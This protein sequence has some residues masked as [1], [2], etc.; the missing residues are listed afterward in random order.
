MLLDWI[1]IANNSGARIRNILEILG[2]SL[3]TYKR[4]KNGSLEDNRKGPLSEPKN[5]ITQEERDSVLAICNSEEF[6]NNPPSQ[7]VPELLSRSIYI[8][9]E[10]TFYRILHE[11][12]MLTHRLNSKLSMIKNK[13]TPLIATGK[14]QVWTWDITYL[15]STVRGRFFYLYLVLDIYSRKI[16]GAVV[17]E[18]ESSE[19]A[20]ILAKELSNREGIKV[21]ELT[22]HSD[23]GSPMKGA[24]MLA[25]LHE[26]GIQPSF[27]RPSVSNDNPY[28]ES[29][30]RTLKYRPEYPD[31]PFE[32]SED[33]QRWVDTFVYWYNNEHRHS[34]LNFVTPAVRHNGD[35]V[36]ELKGRAKVLE[37]AK[38]K[39][40][41]RWASKIRN[42]S[43][44]GPVY[45]NP[46]KEKEKKT[47]FAIAA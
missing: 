43:P 22:L 39:H 19:L 13:P 21:G 18:K 27:S 38:K 36:V 3:K 15:A 17:H 2:L 42:C 34:S 23:N 10:S 47:K 24:T 16:M 25:T 9:S 14:N 28:S 1:S 32:T 35:D 33:A 46:L 40:P 31:K 12:K 45:L 29:T 6:R 11:E 26:L 5:K 20:G 7:I 44:I 37:L 41:E 4:W 30:F 8:A